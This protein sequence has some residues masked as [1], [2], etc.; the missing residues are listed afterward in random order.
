VRN[1]CRIVK[2]TGGDGNDHRRAKQRSKNHR[3]FPLPSVM[4]GITAAAATGQLFS[5][6]QHDRVFRKR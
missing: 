1:A 5:A 3:L 2:W 6:L 4:A